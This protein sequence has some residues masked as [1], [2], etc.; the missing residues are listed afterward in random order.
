MLFEHVLGRV[1]VL[2]LS[3]VGFLGTMS[4]VRAA[5]MTAD[6]WGVAASQAGTSRVA[7]PAASGMTFRDSFGSW[8][9]SE[10]NTPV[11]VGAH[12]VSRATFVS[13]SPAFSIEGGMGATFSCA[14]PVNPC[15]G[16]YEVT[17]RLPFAVTGLSG[18]LGT[19]LD[20]SL[21]GGSST[22][23]FLGISA[24][25]FD[26]RTG[27][28]FNGFW[29]KTFEA[30]DVIT[31]LWTAGLDSFDGSIAFSLRNSVALMASPVAVPEP[32]SVI[33]LITGL[34]GLVTVHRTR[35]RLTV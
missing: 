34:L 14:S 8:T 24:N 10:A 18:I 1:G 29:A 2:F 25:H 23:P 7:L 31:L 5:F 35:T 28:N 12:T 11:Q 3:C 6:E 20:T 19:M 9:T 4:P 33:I 16:V 32:S 22:L 21:P 15:L 30:T 13:G 26:P 17:Y 27:P